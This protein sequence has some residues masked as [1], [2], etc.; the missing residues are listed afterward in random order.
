VG[1]VGKMLPEC[2]NC[3]AKV[4]PS[5]DDKTW[6]MAS[7]KNPHHKLKITEILCPFCKKKFRWVRKA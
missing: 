7:P 1:R 5:E 2:P 3:K 6:I 4:L